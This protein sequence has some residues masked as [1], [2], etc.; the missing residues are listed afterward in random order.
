REEKA[1]GAPWAIEHMY[2]S[3]KEVYEFLGVPEKLGLRLR[4]GRHSVEARDIEAYMDWLD[5]QFGRTSTISWENERFY[6]YSFDGWKTLRGKT[7]AP[8]EFRV[9]RADDPLA[10]GNK[11]VEFNSR[12][13]GEQVRRGI[14]EDIKGLLGERPRGVPASPI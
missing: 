1:G 12:G 4:D 6:N 13:Q 10:A 11:G 7:I 14:K 9:I 5:V 2:Q 8:G 3:L